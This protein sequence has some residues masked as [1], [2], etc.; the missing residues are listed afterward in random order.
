MGD[1]AALLD[2]FAED[3]DFLDEV[4][5]EVG[6]VKIELDAN[7]VLDAPDVWG[8]EDI[9]VV[10]AEGEDALLLLDGDEAVIL[11]EIIVPVNIEEYIHINDKLIYI[12][13]LNIK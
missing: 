5:N 1:E 3:G 11:L 6:F 7:L 8:D 10:V 12:S 2:I 4:E 13:T 9:L